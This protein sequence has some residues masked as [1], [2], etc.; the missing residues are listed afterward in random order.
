MRRLLFVLLVLNGLLLPLTCVP[1]LFL[2][3][4]VNPMQLT[5]I[6]GFTV[7][8]RT[9]STIYVTPVGTVGAE[10][11]RL[12]LPMAIWKAPWVPASQR[13]RFP[14]RSGETITLYYDWDD[15][16]FSELVVEAGDGELR[17]LVINTE[18][19]ANQYTVPRVTDFVIDDLDR[20]GPIDPRVREAHVAAQQPVRWWPI[21]TATATP[22]V[23][24]VLLRRWYRRLKAAKAARHAEPGSV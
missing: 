14:V 8:N 6:T 24:F 2:F 23:T 4:A 12:P 1:A 15:I 20:L 19:T 7:E 22:A 10:G 3:N 18:P 17:Q 16:N 21:V 11:H 13:G 5:F 9:E